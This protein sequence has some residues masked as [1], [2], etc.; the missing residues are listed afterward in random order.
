[1]GPAGAARGAAP[2]PGGRADAGPGRSPVKVNATGGARLLGRFS[3]APPGFV[4]LR[5]LSIYRYCS[6]AWA[7]SHGLRHTSPAG[8]R[9]TP[10]NSSRP[11]GTAPSD[12]SMAHLPPSRATG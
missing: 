3:G 10:R 11:L 9:S 8:T 7:M 1:M 12:A 2:A 6:T 4:F 5:Y